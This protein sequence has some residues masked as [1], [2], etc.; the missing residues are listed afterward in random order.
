MHFQLVSQ[1]QYIKTIRELKL[2]E[3]N[4]DLDTGEFRKENLLSS[5]SI[6]VFSSLL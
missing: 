6:W 1:I 4:L 5:P 3:N 2:E